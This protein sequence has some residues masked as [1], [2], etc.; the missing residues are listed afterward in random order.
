MTL[1]KSQGQ[2]W[3]RKRC[4]SCG[5]GCR[6]SARISILGSAARQ[7]MTMSSSCLKTRSALGKWRAAQSKRYQILPLF[8]LPWVVKFMS[9]RPSGQSSSAMSP[10]SAASW[11]SAASSAAPAPG[12]LPTAKR[13]TTCA[14]RPATAT[15]PV[16]SGSVRRSRFRHETSS[17][18]DRTIESTSSGRGVATVHGPPARNAP[19]AACCGGHGAATHSPPGGPTAG[20]A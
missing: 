18:A 17:G 2:S 19:G 8:C 4:C 16:S 15:P 11:A 13:T 1:Q 10:W 5:P 6:G 7:S 14:S 3:P 9:L 12:G 20:P